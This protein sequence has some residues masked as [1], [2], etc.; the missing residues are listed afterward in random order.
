[1]KKKIKVRIEFGD[2]WMEREIEVTD[3]ELAQ[4][5]DQFERILF[6]KELAN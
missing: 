3:I 2:K 6:S 1:M 5:E 4:L